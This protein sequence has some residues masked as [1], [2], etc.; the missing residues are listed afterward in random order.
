MRSRRPEDL[1][2][3][4]LCDAQPEVQPFIIG[5]L[6]AARRGGETSL[7]IHLHAGTKA[8]AVAASTAQRD[9]QPVRT[10]ATVHKN[11]G[12]LT[13]NGGH[14]VDPSV[15]VEIAEGRS[16]SCKQRLSSRVSLLKATVMI[17]G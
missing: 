9:C 8:V 11:A 2:R 16:T 4:R 10:S 13:Q 17:Q 15:V 14:H 6:V 5:G 7:S 12:M 1:R 3:G